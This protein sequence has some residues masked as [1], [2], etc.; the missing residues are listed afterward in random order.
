VKTS[1]QEYS[2]FNDL[3]ISVAGCITVVPAADRTAVLAAFGALA[4]T[5]RPVASIDLLGEGVER[6]PEHWVYVVEAG[7]AL[8]VMEDNGYQGV[9]PEVLGPASKA[10]GTHKAAAFFWN[11][12]SLTDFSAARR[13]KVVCSVELLAS[14]DEDLD[15]VPKSLR[16]LVIEGGSEQGDMLAA[17]GGLVAAFTDVALTRDVLDDGVFYEIELPASPLRSFQSDDDYVY[18]MPGVVE[19][20]ASLSV[21]QQRQFAEWVTVAAVR[22]AGIQD[23]SP[24]Q[25]LLAELG[26]GTIPSLPPPLDGLARRTAKTAGAFQR[27]TEDLEMGGIRRPEHPFYEATAQTVFGVRKEI[28]HLEGRYL[29]QRNNA[30]EAARYLTHEDPFSAAVGCL[31]YASSSFADGRTTRGAVFEE[32]ETGRYLKDYE[33]NPRHV[34]FTG[35]VTQLLAALVDDLEV[36]DDVWERADT[37]LPAAL[38]SE[39]RTAAIVADAQAAINGDFDTHQIDSASEERYGDHEG[40]STEGG[41][42]ARMAL[43]V[44]ASAREGNEPWLNEPPIEVLAVL[45]RD[46]GDGQGLVNGE[47]LPA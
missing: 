24:V 21:G 44:D 12:N 38:G 47:N 13:G 19:M 4:D 30:V 23:E 7:D 25:R 41:D 10:S 5:N 6:L 43:F 27:L 32:N 15:D 9:R 29:W 8:V 36:A 17:G 1:A 2:W 45:G 20:I 37:E 22:E 42:T 28:S 40:W 26:T 34:Q 39:E 35:V 11:V 16:R 14:E 3:S 46:V 31:N 18:V 33:P